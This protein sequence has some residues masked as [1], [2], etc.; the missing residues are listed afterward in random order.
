MFLQEV[1]ESLYKKYGNELSNLALVFPNK[2]PSVFFRQ[3]LGALITKPIWSPDLFTIHEFIQLSGNRLSADR[4]YQS[5]LLYEA[6]SEVMLQGGETNISSYERFY[7]LGEIL[8]NDF[9]ELESNAVAIADVYTNMA[10]LAAIDQGFDYLTEEQKDFLTQFWNNFSVERL[11]LQKEKFLQLWQKL[12]AIFERFRVLLEDKNL[13]TTGTLYRNLVNGTQDNASFMDSYDKVVFIGFNALNRAELQLFARWKESGK[14]IFYFDT[15]HHYIDDPLQEA[16][17]FLRRNI[18]LFGNELETGNT[19]NRSDRPIHIISAEGNAAQVR[20]LPELLKD[21]PAVMEHP[22]KVAVFLADENQLIP[23]LHALPS[24]LPYVNITMGYGLAQSPVFSLVQTIVRVQESL[25]RHGGKRIYYQPL[26]QLLQHPYLYEVTDA[27]RLA[28][29]INEKSIVSIP[30]EKWASIEEKRLKMILRPLEKPIEL[31]HMVR[32]VLE[33]QATESTEGVVG[34][35]EAQLLTATYYQLNRLEDLLLQFDHPLSLSFIG[36]ILISVLRS[37]SVPLEG[38]PLKGLQVMGLLES[39]GLDFQHII[40]L[41]VNEGVLPKKAVAPTFIP[42][43]IRRAYGLSVMENQDAIFAYVFY[44]LLQKAESVYC[45]YNNTI[46][47]KSTGEQSR[48]LTQL[49]YETAIPVIR[50][51]VQLLVNPQAKPAITIEKDDAILQNLRVYLGQP[52]TP[53]AINNYID[54]RLKF[55]FQHVQKIRE[56]ESFQD[57][58]DA[59]ML[60]NILHRAIEYLYLC[61]AETKSG[62][63][64]IVAA[65]I[66]LMSGKIE[67]A[68]G[69][70]F[71]QELAGDR[72]HEVEFTG[73]Y[74]VIAEV[75]RLYIQEILKQDKAY[76]PFRIVYM[77][78]KLKQ[79]FPVTVGGE[80]W[81]ILLGGTI[82]RVDLKN[83]VYR[84]IDYKTGRDKKDIR[85]V[86]ALF[87]RNS[88]DRNKAALQTIIYTH[89]MQQQVGINKPVNAGLY[90]VRNMRREGE[91][92]DWRFREQS[93]NGNGVDHL[94]MNEIITET[95]ER[96]RP[97]IEEVFDRRVPFDQTDKIEKCEYCSFRVLCGR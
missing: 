94:R 19:I 65:D 78:G 14:A 37:L 50:K 38:E 55:Y 73:T 48:F 58:I 31:I 16:G 89:V 76:T 59:R 97:V 77:E 10:D 87:D 86:D 40:L 54:C 12:P 92:F 57:E 11:S 21:I 23:V 52:L 85:S 62:E 15:D 88:S 35:L 42:D 53:S 27:A 71:G 79:F 68:I 91:K 81:R 63:Q 49:E 7:S 2:R 66:D 39:R 44:R 83:G 33:H 29:E 90:D 34:T 56:P 93:A 3:H 60:G 5:F 41:N 25:A 47:D 18:S 43:S 32:H 36:E 24:S 1:A 8:L 70:A 26:L 46:D 74:K 9:T 67:W 4:L 22:E 84:I 64:E 13:T 95:V 80:E 6:Y 61:V 17:L 20:V 51:S 75:I 72:N 96:L 69:Q 30:A 28:T 45:L 82:D